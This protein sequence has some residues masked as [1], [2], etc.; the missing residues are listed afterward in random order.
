[1]RALLLA[2][3]VLLAG[4]AEQSETPWRGRILVMGTVVELSLYGLTDDEAQA[5]GQRIEADLQ[6]LHDRLH[7]WQGNGELRR[8]NAALRDGQPVAA[9]AG[10]AALLRHAQTLTRASDGLFDPAIAPLIRLWGFHQETT[11]AQPPPPGELRAWRARRASLDELRFDPTSASDACVENAGPRTAETQDS[12]PGA[13]PAEECAGT[14]L[15]P[16]A[17]GLE[18]DLGA[19]AK[20]Y[21]V[22]R[23]VEAARRAGARAA[24]VN[25]GGD[26][27]TLGRPAKR[28]WRIGIRHP[29]ESG[30]LAAVRL[31]PGE[32]IFTSG[33]YE[34]YFQH[35]GRRYHHLLDPRS[36]EPAR[37]AQSLTV[38]TEQGTLADAAA[39]A[40]FVAGP[41]QWPRLA[42][43]LGIE[44][45]LLMDN[46]GRA[47]LSPAM[48]ER[49]RFERE[50]AAVLQVSIP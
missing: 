26:L 45:V 13:A 40:L 16:P 41:T 18:L 10:L 12:R 1:M 32:C 4:C 50:P 3:V 19:F 33:D 39:T 25:A 27:C 43:R 7:P 48:A 29:R 30:V 44:R 35:Q 49:L 47:R 22:D 17:Q 28:D 31:Q 24:I 20:G 34:R 37:G 2:A 21:A 14:R 9:S 8:V 38:I 46:Q 36:G 15:L 23:A 5:L 6:R 11:P 42:A